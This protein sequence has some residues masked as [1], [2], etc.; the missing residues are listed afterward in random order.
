MTKA[1]PV[2]KR[3]SEIGAWAFDADVVIV[4]FGIA[5]A[6]AALEAK[7]AGADVL[8]LERAS[9]GGGTSALSS[10]IFYL[11]GGTPVQQACGVEDDADNMYR[12]MLTACGVSDPALLRTFC[13][14][15]VAHFNWLE[16]Q[17]VPFERSYFKGKH[18]CPPSKEGLVGTGNEKV[19]PNRDAARPAARGHRVAREGDNAGSLAMEQLLTRVAEAGTRILCDAH[20]QSLVRAEDGAICGV[21][22][23][24]G[25]AEQMV[26]AR[27]GVII[28]AGGF[29]MNREMIGEYAPYLLPT[30]E[31]IGVPYNDGAGIRLGQSAGGAVEAMDAIHATACFY[32]PA[33]LIK[34]IVVNTQGQRFVSE[35]SYHGRTAAFIMEQ[36]GRR[37]YLIL[38]SEIFAYP[39]LGEFF[40][41]KLIDGFDSID[42]ME[43]GLKLPAG[44]LSST[45][46]AYNKHAANGQDPLLHKHADWLKPLDKAPYAA[47]DISLDQAIYRYHSL[48]GLKTNAKAQVMGNDG[49]PIKGLYAAGACASGIVLTPKGYGSGMTLAAASFFGRVAGREAAAHTSE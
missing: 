35:D 49:A 4:G 20:V 38:D 13:D 33:Q 45:I 32:P 48:G 2:L 26:R 42:A 25:G 39:D 43:Q 18:L 7:A 24:H 11:G 27:K 23:R 21:S 31:A 15:N 37:A 41:Y 14:G 29:Q 9:A 5:G 46:A 6:C 17:G 16:S 47:F 8:V 40:G 36:P 19:W 34:G 10:G 3:E 22:L 12:Y 44:S 28:A 1:L 30:A